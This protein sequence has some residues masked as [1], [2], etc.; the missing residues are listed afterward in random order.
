MKIFSLFRDRNQ[1]EV[2]VFDSL[3]DFTRH[4]EWQDVLDDYFTIID[5]KG[6][7]YK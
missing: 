6:N 4:T 3:E 1:F 5:E 7:I 2:C